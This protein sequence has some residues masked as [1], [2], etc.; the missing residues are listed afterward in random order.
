M[1]NGVTFWGFL[2]LIL[3]CSFFLSFA[4]VILLLISFK[5]LNNSINGK[6]ELHQQ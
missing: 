6:K 4:V 3:L 5:P 1:D 2:H